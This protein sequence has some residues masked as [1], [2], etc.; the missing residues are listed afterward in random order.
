MSFLKSIYKTL[1]ESD[2]VFRDGNVYFISLRLSNFVDNYDIVV[3]DDNHKYKFTIKDV[4]S[5]D[6]R[7][8]R[9]VYANVYYWSEEIEQLFPSVVFSSRS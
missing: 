1:S 5:F 4:K 8:L 2:R 3:F 6:F 9:K 7:M